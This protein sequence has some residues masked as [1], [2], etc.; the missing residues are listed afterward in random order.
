MNDKERQQIAHWVELI[1]DGQA[2]A[3]E[4]DKL[5]SLLAADPAAREL[6][7]DLMNQDAHMRLDRVSLAAIGNTITLH[8][9]QFN[10]SGLTPESDRPHTRFSGKA[11]LLAAVAGIAACFVTVLWWG[12]TSS[13]PA[14]VARITDSAGAE[15]GECT[16]PTAIDAPL[17]TGRLKL[18]RGL[19]TIR[20]TSGAVVTL[21]APAE[22]VVET[23]MK[24]TLLS[25][26]AVVDVPDAA[27]GFAIST[28]TAEAIDHGTAFAVIVDAARKTSSIEVL[29][30]EVEVRHD[31]SKVSRRLLENQR[32]FASEVALSDT[33]ASNDESEVSTLDGLN[34]M[35]PNVQRITTAMG[36]GADATVVQGNVFGHERNEMILIK[37]PI[38]GF[39][40]YSR[41]GYFAFDLSQ[42][43]NKPAS[44]AQFILTLRPS[45]LG[46]ASHVPDCQFTV[47]GLMDESL[48]DWSAES[49]S[50]SSAPANRD[51]AAAV[52]EGLVRELG[53]FTVPRGKQ[54][55]QVSIEGPRLADFLNSDTNQ[56]ITLVV[57]RETEEKE[58]D[59]LV[60]GF[61]SR[62][63]STA[64]P[65]TLLIQVSDGANE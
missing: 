39:E 52:N 32:V 2:S 27:H 35:G 25:G 60:H 48:D 63:S 23:P 30:G 19:A 8:D 38:G 50:W 41:K 54:F 65:P 58:E 24:A 22:L 44:N 17:G 10:S 46:F 6:Y 7:L 14:L 3:D 40:G 16:L 37:N 21:E 55:G 36:S 18:Y 62:L 31:N 45:G 28:P 42:L 47:Y 56:R 61:A 29:D 4:I 33:S 12:F 9:N 26:T 43:V 59:G 34:P 13:E 1:L 51:G 53:R 5:E 20:F 15:W 57:V 64:A 49:L 11:C